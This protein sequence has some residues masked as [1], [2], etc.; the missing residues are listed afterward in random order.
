[1][2]HPIN[3]I[4]IETQIEN[5]IEKNLEARDKFMETYK[6]YGK[7]FEQLMR[8]YEINANDA[9]RYLRLLGLRCVKCGGKV[10]FPNLQFFNFQVD[11][12]MCYQCQYN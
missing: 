6:K 12:V 5:R 10:T 3:T 8:S 1:M 9:I 7:S 4:F 11:K 2:S